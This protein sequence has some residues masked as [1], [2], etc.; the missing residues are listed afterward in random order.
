M[1]IPGIFA[2]LAGGG[3]FA[4]ITYDSNTTYYRRYN[5]LAADSTNVYLGGV[6]GDYSGAWNGWT[7]SNKPLVTK[8]NHVAKTVSFHNQYNNPNTYMSGISDMIMDGSS[9]WYMLVGGE[10]AWS[11][12]TNQSRPWVGKFNSGDSQQW[13]YEYSAN[14]KGQSGLSNLFFSGSTIYAPGNSNAGARGI[15]FKIDSS[16]GSSTIT[17]QIANGAGS[18]SNGVSGRV[19]SDGK[20][21]WQTWYDSG[22]AGINLLNSNNTINSSY[23]TGGTI[24]P[25]TMNLDGNENLILG[26]N[27][28]SGAARIAKINTSF[29]TVWSRGFTVSG[30]TNC[31]R[32]VVNTATN[33][34]YAAM[35]EIY[36]STNE[37]YYS[38]LVKYNSSGSIQWQRRFTS[39]FNG[40]KI[41]DMKIVGT[42][43]HICGYL[44]GKNNGTKCFYIKISYT[45]APTAQTVTFSNGDTIT[46]DNGS[47][48]DSS[49]TVTL[50]S[51]S[52][53]WGSDGAGTTSFTPSS[54]SKSLT[55]INKEIV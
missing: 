31:E 55:T 51:A 4:Y 8:I 11:G 34:V 41:N 44:G 18:Y 15:F 16:S 19:Y 17:Q 14:S 1:Q 50:T 3:G 26:G 46:I 2:A 37:Y 27:N 12:S 6:V 22:P 39:N 48:T 28:N 23:T 7:P 36:D 30:T 10:P 24:Y 13:G 29:S 9:N 35:S 20:Y 40:L 49:Q 38:Y 53:S 52:Y 5:A 25:G 42:D 43:L 54:S 21:L 33:D 47:G 45:S 32:V